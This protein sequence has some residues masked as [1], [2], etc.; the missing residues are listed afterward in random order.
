M[1][2]A[3]LDQESSPVYPRE[4]RVDRTMK[5]A[6]N[7]IAAF[8][9]ALSLRPLIGALMIRNG[10]SVPGELLGFALGAGLAL[11]FFYLTSQ[12]L[13]LYDDAIA[14]EKWFSRRMLKRKEILGYRVES[15]RRYG[16]CYV[17]VPRR[18]HAS[19]IKITKMFKFDEPLYAW[20]KS[21]ERL[22]D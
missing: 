5:F 2:N 3:P 9:L 21:L 18:D 15:A 1:N 11:W 13:I 19:R 6:M 16:S 7:S 12:R 17:I 22:R 10:A 4:Y 8:L 20:I 14:V